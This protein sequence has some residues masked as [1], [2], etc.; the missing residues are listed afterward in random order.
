MIVQKATKSNIHIYIYILV[1]Q[2]IQ[3]PSVGQML[4]QHLRVWPNI[5]PELGQCMS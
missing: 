4:C 5:D 2:M 3:G 1:S